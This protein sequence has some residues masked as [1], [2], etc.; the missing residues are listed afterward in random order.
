LFRRLSVG[1]NGVQKR[2]RKS[3]EKKK[4]A[5]KGKD[6]KM[7]GTFMQ[8]FNVPDVQAQPGGERMS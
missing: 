3:R 8:A 4:R 1:F 5:L 2:K 7:R 6:S